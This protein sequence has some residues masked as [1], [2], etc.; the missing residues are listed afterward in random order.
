MAL[1][2]G[3]FGKKAVESG[4]KKITVGVEFELFTL[5]KD[6]G[7]IDGAERLISRVRKEAPHVDITEECGKNMI[8]IRSPYSYNVG[9]VMKKILQDFESLLSIADKEGIVLF[10]YGTY[11]GSFTPNIWNKK[12]YR[13]QQMVFGKR[14][15]SIAARCVGMHCH[16]S[17]PKGV[18]DYSSRFLRIFPA[19]KSKS[20]LEN[21]YNFFIAIDPA[22]TVLTQCSPFYQGNLLGKDSRL[23]VY[24]GGSVLNYE[25]GLYSK[26]Q[27]FGALQ[28][29][30]ML[31][32]DLEEIIKHQYDMW[33][34][35]LKSVG[36][37]VPPFLKHDSI[38]DVNW[39]PVKINA[40]GTIEHRG[41]DMTTCYVT[42]HMA[43][44]FCLS[45]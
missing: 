43:P 28:P 18:F 36:V 32:I 27:E 39:K 45:L 34:E 37:V 26:L 14:R 5:D 1:I 16:F 25:K 23:I 33:S 7:M 3:F 41:M 6:G 12:S 2:E 30:K 21:I 35:V 24:R 40:H 8:E 19:Q 38:L 20:A 44:F 9:A 4:L 15:F 13:I 31:G 22:L 42:S 29:Y 11:P 10:P 17:L